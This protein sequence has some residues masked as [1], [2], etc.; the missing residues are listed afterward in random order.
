MAHRIQ[1]EIFLFYILSYKFDS[2]SNIL[3]IINRILTDI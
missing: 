2:N 3:I 1:L